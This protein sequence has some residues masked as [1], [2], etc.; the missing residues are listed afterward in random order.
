M[1]PAKFPVRMV[2]HVDPGL[3]GLLGF[4]LGNSSRKGG[5]EFESN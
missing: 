5:F 2:K 4:V 1:L 3:E